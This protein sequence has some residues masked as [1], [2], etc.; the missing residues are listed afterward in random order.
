MSDSEC[1][2]SSL[3]IKATSQAN[4]NFDEHGDYLDEV[5]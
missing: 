1:S 4:V 3:M 2:F 5:S